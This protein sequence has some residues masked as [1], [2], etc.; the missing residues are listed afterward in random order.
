MYAQLID[1]ALR[2]Y[3]VSIACAT[4]NHLSIPSISCIGNFTPLRSASVH[5]ME[6]LSLRENKVIVAVD[7]GT[8]YSGVAWAK[9]G[10]VSCDAVI[11]RSFY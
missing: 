4:F 3:F 11:E 7:F 10:D 6:R 2:L 8:A 1:F 5:I 9:T